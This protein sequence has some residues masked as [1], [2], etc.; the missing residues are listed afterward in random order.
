M[1][2]TQLHFGDWLLARARRCMDLTSAVPEEHERTLEDQAEFLIYVAAE[3]GDREAEDWV[4]QRLGI[5]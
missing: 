1:N 4:C 5:V 2:T 3:F